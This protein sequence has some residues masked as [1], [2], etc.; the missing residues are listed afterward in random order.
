MALGLVQYSFG[1]K[2]LPEAASEVPNP[3]P[4]ERYPLVIGVAIAGIAV[5]V[6]LVLVGVIRADNLALIVIVTV[7]AAAIAYFVVIL[8]SKRVSA[9][10]RSRVWGFLPLFITSVAF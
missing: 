8:T 1:R 7:I 3:L 2:N 9:D 4:K 6:V 5:I 10:E